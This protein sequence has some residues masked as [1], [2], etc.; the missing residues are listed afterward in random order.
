MKTIKKTEEQEIEK[1][2]EVFWVATPT[3]LVMKNTI[4]PEEYNSVAYTECEYRNGNRGINL[5]NEEYTK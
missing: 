5:I 1:I 2:W 4:T 3:A